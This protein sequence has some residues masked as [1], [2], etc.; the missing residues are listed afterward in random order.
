MRKNREALCVKREAQNPKTVNGSSRNFLSK[1]V[2]LCPNLP[3]SPLAS[4][5]TLYASRNK[6]CVPE[7]VC[8]TMANRVYL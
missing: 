2:R 5:I 6:S 3:S 1:T 7:T 8:G 4:R